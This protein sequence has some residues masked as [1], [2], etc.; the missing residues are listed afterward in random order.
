MIIAVDQIAAGRGFTL[1]GPGIDGSTG[2][3]VAPLPADFGAP[4]AANREQFPRGIDCIFVA[5][6][7]L[8]ALPRSVH[9]TEG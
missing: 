9:L 1:R 2:L 4:R 3:A 6:G 8:A 5:A 7:C